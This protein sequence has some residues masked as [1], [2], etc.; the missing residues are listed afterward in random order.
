MLAEEVEER[1]KTLRSDRQKEKADVASFRSRLD[2]VRAEDISKEVE[3]RTRLP[4]PDDLRAVM[5][6]SSKGLKGFDECMRELRSALET[7]PDTGVAVVKAVAAVTKLDY[8][9]LSF[10]MKKASATLEER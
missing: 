3:A 4:D 5:S 8:K 7:E 10:V 2:S 1:K 6:A 9:A